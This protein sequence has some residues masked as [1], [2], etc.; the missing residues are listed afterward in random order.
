MNK[1][2]LGVAAMTM[3]AL[4]FLPSGSAQLVTA[5]IGGEY[6][7]SS[8]T[9]TCQ[10][11]TVGFHTGLPTFVGTSTWGSSSGACAITLTACQSRA[12]VYQVTAWGTCLPAFAQTQGLAQDAGILCAP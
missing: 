11:R 1:T 2:L 9:M 3:I 5:S 12:P 8:L 4:A 7:C 6:N 10:Y